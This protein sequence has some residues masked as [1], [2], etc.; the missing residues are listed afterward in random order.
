[1][2]SR[3]MTSL[4]IAA[5][6]LGLALVPLT[7]SMNNDASLDIIVHLGDPAALAGAAN[8]VV[9]PDDATIRKGGTQLCVHDPATNACIDPAFANADH[10]IRDGTDNVII[11][12]GENPPFQRIDDPT[13]R[14]FATSIQI[15]TA[16]SAVGG[17]RRGRRRWP[18]PA[19]HY[20]AHSGSPSFTPRFGRRMS[21]DVPCATSRP[22][23]VRTSAS[24]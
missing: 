23:L 7:A 11:E 18:A 15:D 16:G 22:S 1:M 21:V 13:D 17:S 4:V 8:Q 6:A 20:S 14:L 24:A 9:V 12:T 2:N 3:R 5:I 19:E 10:T